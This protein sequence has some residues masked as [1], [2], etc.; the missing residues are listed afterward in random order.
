METLPK[1]LHYLIMLNL[2]S[3]DL[4][5]LV[6]TGTYFSTIL[7]EEEFW[8]LRFT[9][10]KIK[11]TDNLTWKQKCIEHENPLVSIISLIGLKRFL[12][13][14]I[15]LFLVYV[16]V[17]D[18]ESKIILPILSPYELYYVDL[19]DIMCD[20]GLMSKRTYSLSALTNPNTITK[21][22]E[23]KIKK[24][25]KR[26]S[27]SKIPFISLI[28]PGLHYTKIKNFNREK[29][30]AFTNVINSEWYER[31]KFLTFVDTKEEL[32]FCHKKKYITLEDFLISVMSIKKL[33]I[34]DH[35]EEKF[36]NLKLN[37][38]KQRIEI[39]FSI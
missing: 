34:W 3:I 20:I 2:D 8:R 11:N 35:D 39:V 15:Q 28:I 14:S 27:K 38:L 18:F 17:T 6:F 36:I 30:L 10:Y 1:C 4:K 23:N 9:K 32:K 37:L 26:I 31:E 13:L 5:S 7:N 22:E 24:I 21:E 12:T 33:K 25:F 29:D 16:M 19:D